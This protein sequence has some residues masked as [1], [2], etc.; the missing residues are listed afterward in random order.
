MVIIAESRSILRKL[1]KLMQ[2]LQDKVYFDSFLISNKEVINTHIPKPANIMY[3]GCCKYTKNMGI[4]HKRL[5]ND[6][7]CFISINTPYLFFDNNPD[8]SPYY[9]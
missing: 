5:I 6:A 9:S 1:P 7:F 8:D 4:I 3:S 2:L